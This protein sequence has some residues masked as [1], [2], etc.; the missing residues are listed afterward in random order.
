MPPL[1]VDPQL[2]EN[3]RS[4]DV[5]TTGIQPSLHLASIAF[6]TVASGTFSVALCL[7]CV[8][9]YTWTAGPNERA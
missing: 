6:I 4:S 2:L 3:V 7:L 5:L 1:G 8:V 9:L